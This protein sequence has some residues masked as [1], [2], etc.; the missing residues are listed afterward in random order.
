[1]L[2]WGQRD[3]DEK[4]DPASDSIEEQRDAGLVVLCRNDDNML[5]D[6]DDDDDGLLMIRT[7]TTTR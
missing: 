2:G 4:S 6:D 5:H 7:G 1:M 3:G